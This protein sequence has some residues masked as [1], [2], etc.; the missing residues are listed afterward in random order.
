LSERALEV[1]L[2]K[3]GQ[4]ETGTESHLASVSESLTNATLR[5]SSLSPN[6]LDVVV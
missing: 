3:F 6:K 2:L 4:A 1:D 5:K